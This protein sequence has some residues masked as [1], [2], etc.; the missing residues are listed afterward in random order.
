MA[1]FSRYGASHHKRVSFL[2]VRRAGGHFEWPRFSEHNY[3][4]EEIWRIRVAQISPMPVETEPLA[5]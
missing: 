1:P 4:L 5:G 3:A 2:V